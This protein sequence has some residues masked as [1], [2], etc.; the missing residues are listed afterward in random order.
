MTTRLLACLLALSLSCPVLLH[1]STIAPTT[2]PVRIDLEVDPVVTFNSRTVDFTPYLDQEFICFLFTY[3]EDWTYLGLRARDGLIDVDPYELP[4]DGTDAFWLL[5]ID[6]LGPISLTMTDT[7][8]LV[9]V[10]GFAPRFDPT[11]PESV[12][13]PATGLLVL[14]GLALRRHLVSQNFPHTSQ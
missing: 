14:V 7:T 6:T 10:A 1:A 13:E 12:P 5:P 11:Q 8:G 3:V 2:D 9:H 4:A